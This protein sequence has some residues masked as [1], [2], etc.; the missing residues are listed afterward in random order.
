MDLNNQTSLSAASFE[1]P[2]PAAR[3]SKYVTYSKYIVTI[4]LVVAEAGFAINGL[5]V[6]LLAPVTHDQVRTPEWQHSI[7]EKDFSQAERVLR[8]K[9]MNGMMGMMGMKGKAKRRRMEGMC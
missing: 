3:Q 9:Y 5:F 6:M 8:G 2:N 4:F 7:A 1:A